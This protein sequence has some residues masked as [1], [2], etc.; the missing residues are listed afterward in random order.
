MEGS[1]SPMDTLYGYGLCMGNHTPK[2]AEHKVQV[3]PCLARETFGDW[4]GTD[5][6]QNHARL[7][8]KIHGKCRQ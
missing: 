7:N 4:L 3:P 2:I 1:S 5:L 8:P 6:E